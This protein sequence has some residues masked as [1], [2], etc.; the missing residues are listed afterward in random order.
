MDALIDKAKKFLKKDQ[1]KNGLP[2][3]MVEQ[4]R[5]MIAR[6]SRS[7]SPS[8][9]LEDVRYAVMDLETTGFNHAK[10]DEIIAAGA[11]IVK[12]HEIEGDK[13]FHQLVYPYRE[14]PENVLKLTGIQRDMLV[15]RL[16]FFGVLIE[17]LDFIGN[18][19]IVGHNIGFDLGFINPKLKKYCRTKIKNRTLDTIALADA[20]HIPVKSYSLDNLVAYYGIEAGERHTAIG[21]AF[22]TAQLLTHLL[23][24]LREQ[25]VR[26]LSGLNHF[27]K[28]HTRLGNEKIF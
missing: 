18:S 12:G 19:V 6:N 15:G 20:L 21:D 17:F 4:I 14:V 2:P 5:E 16:G 24:A 8:T 9:L 13:T 28:Q 7:I 26:T 22:L 3:F 11:V 23:T 25:N 1:D 27:L 10:G